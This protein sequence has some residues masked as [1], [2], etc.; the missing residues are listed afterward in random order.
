MV[1]RARVTAA[2]VSPRSIASRPKRA[3]AR[4]VHD[5]VA[6]CRMSDVISTRLSAPKAS[7]ASTRVVSVAERNDRNAEP[8]PAAVTSV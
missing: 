5:E 3:T 4:L 7:G 1:N 8:S 6:V 2:I